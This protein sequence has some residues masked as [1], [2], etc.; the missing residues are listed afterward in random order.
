MVAT[1]NRNILFAQRDSTWSHLKT[2]LSTHNFPA[3]G[4]G[5]EQEMRREAKIH[6]RIMYAVYIGKMVFAKH[7]LTEIAREKFCVSHRREFDDE[8]VAAALRPLR[9]N[10]KFTCERCANANTQ[11]LTKRINSVA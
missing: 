6:I 10:E 8:F 11:P 9:R 2:D 1:G 4:G 5:G 3:S 7:I